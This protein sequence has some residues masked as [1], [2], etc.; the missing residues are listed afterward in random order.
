[1]IETV[2]DGDYFGL[3][4]LIAFHTQSKWSEERA[5][6]VETYFKRYSWKDAKWMA[7][8]L[9]A[10]TAYDVKNKLTHLLSQLHKELEVKKSSSNYTHQP[11]YRSEDYN[12]ATRQDFL[13]LHC[14]MDK[15][16]TEIQAWIKVEDPPLKYMNVDIVRTETTYPIGT[17]IPDINDWMKMHHPQT[18]SNLLDCYLV[19]LDSAINNKTDVEYSS[20]FLK[21]IMASRIQQMKE[22]TLKRTRDFV[23]NHKQSDAVNHVAV[24]SGNGSR[25]SDRD[26]G[27]TYPF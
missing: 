15:I 18:W 24:S 23:A 27:E 26:D 3:I 25:V 13:K 10:E 5:A 8:A 19:G 6:F 22:R 17:I 9:L 11:N 12:M 4:K 16:I 7:E 14:S 20:E 1:M 21:N 2:S